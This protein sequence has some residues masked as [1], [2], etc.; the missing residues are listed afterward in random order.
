MDQAHIQKI[1]NDYVTAAK[2]Q[3]PDNVDDEFK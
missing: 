2:A 3:L 1:E